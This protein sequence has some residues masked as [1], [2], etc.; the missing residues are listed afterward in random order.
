MG[1]LCRGGH[2]RPVRRYALGVGCGFPAW[3]L[4][5]VPPRRP[6]GRLVVGRGCAGY[7]G[8]RRRDPHAGAGPALGRGLPALDPVSGRQAGPHPCCC[9]PRF[10]GSSSGDDGWTDV[11]TLDA[12]RQA[13]CDPRRG[14][15]ERGELG[16]A[17]SRVAVAAV[18]S[19]AWCG[20]ARLLLPQARKVRAL[21]PTVTG[22]IVEKHQSMTGNLTRPAKRVVTRCDNHARTCRG[23][24]VI[25]VDAREAPGEED[26]KVI[27]IPL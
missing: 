8:A 16:G 4:R 14:S 24:V 2:S 17:R 25:T 18:G 23:G 9:R 19:R 3:H 5:G 13:R 21:R 12:H 26:T 15:V 22:R 1:Y 11:R 20:D 7:A 10:A 27:L 6:G